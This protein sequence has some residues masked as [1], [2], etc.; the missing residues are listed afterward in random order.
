MSKYFN[1]QEFRCKGSGSP[2]PSDWGDRFAILCG[3]LDAIREEWGGPLVVVSGYRDAAYNQALFEQSAAR[4]HGVSGVA[5]KSQH[6][7]GRA[8]D[9]APLADNPERVAQLHALILEMRGAL[10][11]MGGLGLYPAWVHVD[12]RAHGP[13]VLAQWGGNGFGSEKT[14]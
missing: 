9:I 11:A 7:Q 10:P 13:G 8:A 4:N 3:V 12:I 5:M 2:Y 14:A 6:I 1:I